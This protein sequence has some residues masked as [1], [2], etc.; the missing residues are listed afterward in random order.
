[1]RRKA[2]EDTNYLQYL[3]SRA[4]ITLAEALLLVT[5]MNIACSREVENKMLRGFSFA[6]TWSTFVFA[7]VNC[8]ISIYKC[9][10]LI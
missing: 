6:C 9:L 3:S 5:W 2:G 4:I 1:M 7:L 10:H 8:L